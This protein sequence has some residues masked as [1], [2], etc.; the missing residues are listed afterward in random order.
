MF[1]VKV[2]MNNIIYA[3]CGFLLIISTSYFCIALG[4]LIH[5][6]RYLHVTT[7]YKKLIAQTYIYLDFITICNK[8]DFN[9]FLML[10]NTAIIVFF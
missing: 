10:K 2:I 8:S 7:K 5:L 3:L 6:K 4:K 1:V 9:L